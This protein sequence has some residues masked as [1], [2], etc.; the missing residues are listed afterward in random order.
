VAT[1]P[2]RTHHEPTSSFQ[3]DRSLETLRNRAAD[4]S[5]LPIGRKIEYLRAIQRG[6]LG[7]ASELV[8]EAVAAKGVSER[9]GAEDWLSGPIIILRTIRFLIDTLES[10]QRTGRVPID[11]RH[12]SVRS[13]GQV[14][15]RVNPADVYDRIMYRGWRADVWMEP[16][17]A[18]PDLFANTGGIYTKPETATPGVAAVLGAGNVISIGALDVVHKLFVEGKTTMLKHSP[19]NDYGGPYVEQAFAELITDGYLRTSYGGPETGGILVG[20]PA[21]DEVHVTGAA[22]TH[23]TI[24][25]GPGE[26]GAARKARNEPLLEKPITS[27]LGNVSPVIVVPGAWKSRDLRFQAEHL[28]TQMLMN[29]GFNCNAAKV[30]VLHRGWGQREEFL[31]H[32]RAVLLSIPPRPAY[33]P[34]AEERF[35]RFVGSHPA[36]ELLGVRAEGYVPPALLMGVDAGED[37]PA[38]GEESFCSVSAI[39]VLE[40]DDPSDFLARAVDFCNERLS[41][42]LNATVLVDPATAASIRPSLDAAVT[43]LRYGAVGVNIWGGAA[44]GLGTTPWGGFPGQPL[45]DIQSGRGFVHNARLIDR[46][47]KTVIRTPFRMMPKPPWFITHRTAHR[48]FPKAAA[49]EADPSLAR[50][51]GVVLAALLG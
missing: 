51:P 23:D 37:H 48:V 19:V 8:A 17:L 33:Y 12:V 27:E 24:V 38:F 39:T 2:V 25:F 28:A 14:V 20:H 43:D 16:D 44:F 36:A 46:P 10:I 29:H 5:G 11:D 30:V 4:W 40:G 32:L 50:V 49:L 18:R 41:G 42:T 34:G 7:V 45:N 9:T 26:E 35:D 3:I 47:Q 15:A 31:D 1:S 21:V 22:A 13:N 6:T